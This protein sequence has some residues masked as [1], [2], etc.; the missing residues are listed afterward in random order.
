MADTGLPMLALVWPAAWLLLLPIVVAE[1]YCARR[2]L[3]VDWRQALLVSAQANVLSTLVGMPLAWIAM[4]LLEFGVLVPLANVVP[5][6]DGRTVWTEALALTVGAAWVGPDA[7]WH[8]PFAA[9]VLCLPFYATSVEIERRFAR[10]RWSREAASS[11]SRRAN[12]LT[13]GVM[14][15]SL[16]AVAGWLAIR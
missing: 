6:P 14:A 15:G 16:L 7:P 11:W 13:Y 5:I 4:V 12:R 3:R 9:A 2:L 10:T 1:A 8:V